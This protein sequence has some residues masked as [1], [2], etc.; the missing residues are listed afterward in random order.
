MGQKYVINENGE[1][2]RGDYFATTV[3][4]ERPQ[5]LPFNRKALVMFLLNIVTLGIYGIVIWFAMGKETNIT[6]ST[7][8]K[9]T[10]GFWPTLGL[11]IIT[12]GIYF[13][14]WCIQWMKR[15]SDF[16][17]MHKDPVVI[18]GGVYVLLAIA[19]MGLSY[20]LQFNDMLVLSYITSFIISFILISLVIKKHNRVNE[21]YNLEQF[22]QNVK[23]AKK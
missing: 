1:I 3:T 14:V 12:F 13:I 10:K 19:N 7:D 20:A 2:I 8:G 21:I 23:E 6:C 4:E 16:L 5:P 18:T 11:S 9:H 22:P 17:R 15:E